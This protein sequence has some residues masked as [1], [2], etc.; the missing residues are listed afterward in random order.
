MAESYIPADWPVSAKIHAWQTTRLSGHSLDDYGGLNLA[1]TVGDE[2]DH[3]ARNRA[4]LASDLQLPRE[5]EWVRLVHGN[6]VLNVAERTGLEPADAVYTDEAGRVLLIP[7]ADCLPVLF[8][9]SDKEVAAAHAGWRG[10]SAGVLENTV[11]QFQS[12]RDDIHAWFG[13]AIGPERFEVG[14]DVRDAFLL[15]HP[16]CEAA[17]TPLATEGKFLA[18]LYLLATQA[19]ARVGVKRLY[20]G[21]WC[22][23]NDPRFFSYRRQGQR[24]GRMASLIWFDA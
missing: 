8:A 14:E 9:A 3:V 15:S 2:A 12:A 21:Q 13:P 17:F 10:L 5:P 20:G 11:A 7:T 4:Q 6:R 24:C 23:F 19:L 1:T 22:T 16:G 18:D